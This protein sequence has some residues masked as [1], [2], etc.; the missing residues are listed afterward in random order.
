MNH[1]QQNQRRGFQPKKA[2]A[3]SSCVYSEPFRKQ[4]ESN[5]MDSLRI[6]STLSGEQGGGNARDKSVFVRSALKGHELTRMSWRMLKTVLNN[7]YQQ[8]K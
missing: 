7:I 8:E 2:K 4:V 5:Q 3:R 6:L 1:T